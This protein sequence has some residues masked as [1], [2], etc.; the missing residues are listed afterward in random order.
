MEPLLALKIIIVVCIIIFVVWIGYDPERVINR[1]IRQRGFFQNSRSLAVANNEVED[2]SRCNIDTMSSHS[3]GQTSEI[4]NEHAMRSLVPVPVP[5]ST[6]TGNISRGERMMRKVLEELFPLVKP[7]YNVRPSWLKNPK[8][9]RT[10]EYDVYYDI[11]GTKL[12][13]EYNGRQH[14]QHTDFGDASTQIERDEIKRNISLRNGVHLITVPY[15]ATNELTVRNI[16]M[17]NVDRIKHMSSIN[18]K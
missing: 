18:I 9:G 6:G 11:N 10:L 13:F 8:T 15:T 5:E 3:S 7:S 2:Y 4:E 12:A 1:E 14:Y 16:I 17:K